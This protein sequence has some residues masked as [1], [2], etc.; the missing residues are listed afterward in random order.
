MIKEEKLKKG[1]MNN[2]KLKH[3][4]V[5]LDNSYIG[6]WDDVRFLTKEGAI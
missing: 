6:E 2:L 3:D 5:S 1:V 4:L